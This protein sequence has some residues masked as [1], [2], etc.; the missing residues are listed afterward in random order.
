MPNNQKGYTSVS[1]REISALCATALC[2]QYN[3]RV[4][5]SGSLLQSQFPT[6]SVAHYTINLPQS[7]RDPPSRFS[8][9]YVCILIANNFKSAFGS[10]VFK[11]SHTYL[12]LWNIATAEKGADAFCTI[13]TLRISR[14][15]YLRW[16]SQAIRLLLFA[17]LA[18]LS[19][20]LWQIGCAHSAEMGAS[21]LAMQAF[22][23]TPRPQ[24]WSQ[25][26]QSDHNIS[27]V[28]CT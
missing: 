6:N 11:I 10:H 5:V 8:S 12:V 27:M 3:S 17:A 21:N 7:K 20:S 24:Y 14:V 16:G 4:P 15:Y 26:N 9:T 25:I 23:R 19:A 13:S 28:Q 2:D 22:L 1:L 18:S